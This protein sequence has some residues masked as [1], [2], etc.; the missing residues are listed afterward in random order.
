ME[1]ILERSMWH[2]Q[3]RHRMKYAIF[4]ARSLPRPDM[5]LTFETKIWELLLLRHVSE[6][7][8]YAKQNKSELQIVQVSE[9]EAESLVSADCKFVAEGSN[10]RC[11][12]EATSVFGKHRKERK[13]GEAIWFAPGKPICY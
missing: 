6:F 7:P 4:S 9:N 10:M 2:Y 12:Q 11:S 8:H 1:A 13:K 5:I 3:A